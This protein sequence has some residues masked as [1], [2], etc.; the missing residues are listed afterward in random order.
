MR[1]KVRGRV[2]LS[3]LSPQKVRDTRLARP[4]LIVVP[5]SP[6]SDKT[7]PRDHRRN[8]RP[9]LIQPGPEI[10]LVGRPS[11]G[12]PFPA[13]TFPTHHTRPCPCQSMARQDK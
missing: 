3:L 13:E 1:K 6:P 9:P 2:K 5:H 11:L 7:P 10:L 12:S 8:Y 4:N